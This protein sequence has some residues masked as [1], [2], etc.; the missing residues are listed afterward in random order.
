[1]K[2]KTMVML[3]VIILVAILSGLL[4]WYL[5]RQHNAK[6]VRIGEQMIPKEQSSLDFSGQIIPDTALL[7]QFTQL[8]ELNV[9]DTGLTPEDY[10]ALKAA[11]PGC[12][13]LWSVPFQGSYYPEETSQLTVSTLSQEDISGLKYFPALQQIDAL[14]CRDFEALDALK[15]AYPHVEVL[16]QLDVGSQQLTEGATELTLGDGTVEELAQAMARISALRKVDATGCHDYAALEA[17]KQQYPD[18]EIAYTV[19]VGSIEAGPE[20]TALSLENP[21][22]AQLASALPYL[23]QV[24]QVTLSG[25]LPDNDAIHALQLAFPEVAFEWTFSLCGVEVSSLATE[26]DL[27][28][29]LMDSTQEVENSLKYFQ[30]LERVIM[31]DCGIADEDMDA[32]GKRNPQVRF[33]WTVSIGYYIRLRTDATYFMPYLFGATITD[34]DTVALKYCVDLICI[35]VGHMEISDVSF[36][37]YMPHMKYL[38]LCDTNVSDISAVEGMEE[39]I[40]CELFLTQVQDYS[41][42][43]SCKNLKDLNICY[44]VPHNVSA[45]CQMT[46]LENLWMKGSWDEKMK[47]DLIAALPNTYIVFSNGNLSSTGDGWRLLQNYRDMRDILGMYYQYN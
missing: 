25:E 26:V 15:A 34:A 47:S 16:W 6:F 14:T 10:E 39:L 37:A 5:I 22:L 17:L 33:V 2:K 31:C 12:R 7:Q 27:S 3:T 32:L 41:P 29:I 45:L 35:D 11:L 9:T 42:L 1:M 4:G 13:I 21:D 20:T 44:S 30:N 19:T 38:L 23:P 24:R 36:L 46:Q 40:F 43:I 28:N 8:Q 18:C